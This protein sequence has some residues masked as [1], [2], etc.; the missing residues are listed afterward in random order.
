VTYATQTDLVDRFGSAEILQLTDRSGGNLIDTTV[1]GRALA[2]AD[3]EIDA[4]LA[5]R[6][7]LPLATVPAIVVRLAADI[8]RYR[9]WDDRASVE[10]RARY[11]DAVRVLARIADGD[12]SLGLPAASAPAP[13]TG[14][15]WSAPDRRWT[16]DLTGP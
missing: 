7:E 14:V 12:V 10:V 3:A 16:A 13:A 9:L 8:A 5:A 6:Y 1:L 2:D 4:Y 15:A 11:D